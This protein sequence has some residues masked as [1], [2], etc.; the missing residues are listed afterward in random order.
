M[1]RIEF[2]NELKS[3][4]GGFSSTE[5]ARVLEYYEELF[6]DSLE[7]GKTEEEIIA[8][9]DTPE[10]IAERVRVE[11]AFLRAEQKPSAGSLNTVLLIILGLFAL[12]IGLPLAFAMLMVLFAVGMVGVSL[13]IA[14]LA[15]L[16]SLGICGIAMIITG[17]GTVVASAPLAGFALIGAGLICAGLGL[18]TGVGSWALSRVLFRACAKLFRKMYTSVTKRKKGATV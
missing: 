1:T 6:S 5:T 7:A 13:V 4:L 10:A 14:A 11:L 18:L 15:L 2:M 8:G 17:V 3:R 9:L 12:P 16:L